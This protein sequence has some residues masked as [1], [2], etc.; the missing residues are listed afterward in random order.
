MTNNHD[1]ATVIITI[2]ICTLMMGFVIHYRYKKAHFEMWT[3]EFERELGHRVPEF[4]KDIMLRD[5]FD[6]DI[7][8]R[9][10]VAIY[11]DAKS[12]EIDNA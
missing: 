10:S 2:G 11:K 12:R 8:I 3:H 4:D 6:L 7:T 1:I 5:L 9:E